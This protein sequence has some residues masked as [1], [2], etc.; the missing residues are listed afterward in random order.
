MRVLV[1]L[2]SQ[3]DRDVN[4]RED[5]VLVIEDR[6]RAWLAGVTRSSKTPPLASTW[7]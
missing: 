3:E 7:V 6:H 1:L 5:L 4:N 2:R